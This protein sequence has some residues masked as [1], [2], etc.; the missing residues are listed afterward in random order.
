MTVLRMVA[1]VCGA[2]P[3]RIWERSA[4]ASGRYPQSNVTSRTQCTRL[5]ESTGGAVPASRLVVSLGRSPEPGVPVARHRALHE[6][7]QAAGVGLVDHGVGMAL[8]R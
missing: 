1:M 3:V 4:P 8:P 2:V 7:L 5:C 6:S